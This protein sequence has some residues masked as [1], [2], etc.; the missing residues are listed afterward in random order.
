MRVMVGANDLLPA[1]GVD[2]EGVNPEPTRFEA[3]RLR[4]LARR[5]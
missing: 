4:V 1:L 3:V 2:A 5:R